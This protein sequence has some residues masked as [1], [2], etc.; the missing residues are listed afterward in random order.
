M[1]YQR[2]QLPST[3]V[4]APAALP[5]ELVGLTDETLADLSA[6]LDPDACAAL[7]YTGHGFFPVED[8][9]LPPVVPD[10]VSRMQ[11]KMALLAG[12]LLS[13]VEAA[14]GASA[15]PALQLYWADASHFHRDHAAL[16]AMTASLGMTSEQVDALF[17]AASEIV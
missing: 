5:A 7:G 9:P 14:V 4:G 15:D 11:A 12:G 2:K 10:S 17:I 1:R 8:E 13:T 16:I 6:A 3:D